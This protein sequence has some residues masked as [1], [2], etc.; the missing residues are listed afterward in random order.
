MEPKFFE[1]TI[2]GKMKQD[3]RFNW[4]MAILEL[5]LRLVGFKVSHVESNGE[6][7]IRD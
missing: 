4:F 6:R 5:L 3:S 2:S 7:L 1:I